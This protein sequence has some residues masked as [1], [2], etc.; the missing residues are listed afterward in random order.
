VLVDEFQDTSHAQVLL[1]ERLTMDLVAW[2]RSDAVR[3]WATPMQSIYPVPQC[4]GRA[5]HHRA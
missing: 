2:R 3:R 1:L 4:R 5:L